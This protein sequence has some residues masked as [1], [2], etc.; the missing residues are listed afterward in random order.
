MQNG[1]DHISVNSKELIKES[2]IHMN[3]QLQNHLLQLQKKSSIPSDH[4]KYLIG[5]KNNGFMPRVIYDIGAC[6]LHWTQVAKHIWPDAKIVLFDAFD[7]AEFLYKEH[8]Y[9]IG[10]LSATNDK[11]VRFYQNDYLPTGNSYYREIGCC[12]G[13]YFPEDQYHVYKTCT[14]DSIVVEKHFPPPDLIKIDVQGAERDVILGGLETIK[15]CKHL[16]VEMQHTNYNDGAPTVDTTLP[17]IEKHG[18][19]CVAPLFSNNGP[20]GDYGFVN[21]KQSIVLSV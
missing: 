2:Y 20:D 16:I 1:D 19:K 14:L 8:P 11:D 18:F 15:H 10:V 5:L 3:T 9:H 7:K 4:V 17:F 21:A 13:L 6:V 12:N